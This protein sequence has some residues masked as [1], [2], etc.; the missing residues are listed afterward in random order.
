MDSMIPAANA[1]IHVYINSQCIIL[2]F[3]KIRMYSRLFEQKPPQQQKERRA[4]FKP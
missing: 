1:G 4:K 3:L 2:Q